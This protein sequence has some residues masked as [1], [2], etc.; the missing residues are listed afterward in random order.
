MSKL[1]YFTNSLPRLWFLNPWFTA[2]RLFKAVTALQGYIQSLEASQRLLQKDIKALELDRH[3]L[4]V[5][6]QKLTYQ[7]NP[8]TELKERDLNI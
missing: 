3:R 4:I 8:P 5:K 2:V 7:L 6:V 1:T